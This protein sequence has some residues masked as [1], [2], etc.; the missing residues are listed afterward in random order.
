MS[1]Q[2]DVTT[3][4]WSIRRRLLA[5]F[6]VVGLVVVGSG[7][8]GLLL[9]RSSS[10][11][12]RE[13]AAAELPLQRANSQMRDSVVRAASD[14]RAY[15]ITGDQA[16]LTSLAT[17]RSAYRQALADAEQV[18]PA[19]PASCALVRA[20]DDDVRT[21]FS[22][23]ADPVAQ[24]KVSR[25]KADQRYRANRSVLLS[26]YDVNDAL[27]DQVDRRIDDSLRHADRRWGMSLWVL[28][29]TTLL[30]GVGLVLLAWLTVHQ[31]VPALTRLRVVLSRLAAGDLEARVEQRGPQEM[32]A[33]ATSINRL[34]EQSLRLRDAEFV[35]AQVRG[36]TRD[37][38]RRMR[39]HLHGDAVA[40]EVVCGLG[41]MAQA[42]RV[43][44]R[45]VDGSRMGAV[46]AQWT[47]P[48]LDT[49]PPEP[50]GPTHP[51]ESA[52]AVSARGHQSIVVDDI[53]LYLQGGS[54]A[55]AAL[56]TARAYAG[57]GSMIV[58]PVMVGNERIGVLVCARAEGRRR[59][60]AADAG[61]VESVA[62]DLARA[63]HHAR[64]FEQQT[65]VVGQLRELDRTKSDFLSTISHELRTPL[66]SIAGYVEMM[67]DGDAGELQ[68]MQDNML[69]I[70][71]R[72]TQRL[73]DLIEDVLTISRVESGAVRSERLP[74]ALAGVVEHAVD[75]LRPQAEAAGVLIDTYPV[76][77]DA[78]LMA[79][80]G[81][82][83]R[84]LLNL[85]GN[86]V[87]F[88]P[89]R[90]RVTVSV[91]IAQDDVLL[92]VQDTGIGIPKAEIDSLF[93]RFYRASNA[94]QRQIPGT[95]LGLAIISGIVAAHG[96][97]VD[98]DSV[99]GRGTTFTVRLPRWDADAVPGTNGYVLRV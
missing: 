5:G 89:R 3:P 58:A 74:V 40:E 61:L 67:R 11:A 73:R 55:S 68:P 96:G 46:T 49:L 9:S 56:S 88:T 38:D 59:F 19:A 41:P 34:A 17:N 25:A 10:G 84:M 66:T 39:A 12:L 72:N 60:D 57:V 91:E 43:H 27:A 65:S 20:Q 48:A 94:T 76:P 50:P 83:E 93:T 95:G 54:Q 42:D 69:E 7:V 6:A 53:A 8:G 47:T 31:V 1:S 4:S 75:S 80:P 33:V 37:L 24:G 92:R 79:D 15:I 18:C 13:V 99:E 32:R 29:A 70:V 21:W 97:D 45:F 23:I 90:G 98:V 51:L 81:Q 86:A 85:V 87:K 14:L 71:A 16:S 78:L 44:V 26:F 63:V 62:S 30:A 77:V 2:H 36:L 35:R 28:V 52:V 64:L 22:T 82:I